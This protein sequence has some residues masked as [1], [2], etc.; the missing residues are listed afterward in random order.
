M[1]KQNAFV[2]LG[3]IFILFF[4]CKDDSLAP[5]ATFDA[6]EKGAYVRVVEQ[7]NTNLNL[8]DIDNS[9]IDYTIEF[10]DLE[11]GDLVSEYTLL[12]TYEDKNP[13]NGDH[14]AGPVEFRSWSA[15]D[16][17]TSED[18]FKGLEDIKITAKETFEALGITKGD[19]RSGDTFKFSGSVTTTQGATFS[20]S[21]SSA[22]VNGNSFRGFFNFTL[23]AFCPS[24]LEGTYEYISSGSSIACP[25][26]NATENDLRGVVSI[27]AQGD[28]VYTISD[29]SFGAYSV[30]YGE[31]KLADFADLKF[32]DT[33]K[34][35]AFTGKT[36][37]FGDKWS[38]D[39]SV[40][41]DDWKISWQTSAEESGEVTITNPTGWDFTI[42]Q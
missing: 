39:S 8:F 40:E 26:G 28:G 41:G 42:M 4:A 1:K 3:L 19:I 11:K 27:E 34:E 23:R 29:W 24:S 30:C 7:N 13:E 17:T 38:F 10:V 35:V 18:G 6:A 20:A 37:S 25:N 22:A 12:L 33:C 16:F 15:A 5:I 2:G 21:N 36:D 31:G 14:S 32:T 9:A